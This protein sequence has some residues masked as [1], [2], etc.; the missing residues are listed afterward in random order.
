MTEYEKAEA[1]FLYQ[2][3]LDPEVNEGRRRS[4]EQ[5]YIYNSLRPDQREERFRIL[6]NNLGRMGKHCVIEQPFYCD[7]WNRVSVG[8]YFFSNYHFVVLAGNKIE[9]GNHVWIG[10]DCGLY[11]AGH[12]FDAFL[13]AKGLEYAWPIQIGNHVWIGGGTKVMG[14]VVIGDYTVVAAGS[15]VNRDL[16]SHVLAGGNPCR[17]IRRIR[18]EDDEKYRA[19]YAKWRSEQ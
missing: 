15:V 7:F 18:P 13:R 8:D 5:N 3:H 19:G 10:P 4:Q 1:G 16:P 6:K 17:V 14:G 9:I 12:P 2:A 11:A